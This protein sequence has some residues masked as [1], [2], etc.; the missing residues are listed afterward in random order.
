MQG[1]LMELTKQELFGMVYHTDYKLFS[2]QQNINYGT[3]YV[4][5]VD[6]EI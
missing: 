5:S 6:A 1:L 3:L 4:E 2:L